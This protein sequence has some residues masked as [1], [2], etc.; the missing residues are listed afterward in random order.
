VQRNVYKLFYCRLF[1]K[2]LKLYHFKVRAK[3]YFLCKE[4]FE[5]NT[6]YCVTVYLTN[7]TEGMWSHRESDG[8]SIYLYRREDKEAKGWKGM[9][10][11]C[12][13][14]FKVKGRKGFTPS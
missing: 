1:T 6:G 9:R 3:I 4:M 11:M 2:I 10:E 13:T 12:F 8:L 5:Q 7:K 14:L